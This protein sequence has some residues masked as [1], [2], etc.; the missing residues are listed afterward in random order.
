MVLGVGKM[1]ME[2]SVGK[3][4]IERVGMKREMVAKVDKNHN[5]DKEALK[6]KGLA[7]VS[8][9]PIVGLPKLERK[10]PVP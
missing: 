5:L 10:N 8:M 7:P 3:V 6:E 9:V 4:E 2:L 1:E